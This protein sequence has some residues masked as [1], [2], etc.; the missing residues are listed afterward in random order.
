MGMVFGAML[1]SACQ[2]TSNSTNH[3]QTQL[4]K[5][6]KTQQAVAGSLMNVPP[7]LVSSDVGAHVTL[8]NAIKA[9]LRSSFSYHSQISYS[10]ELRERALL[11][12]TPKQLAESDNFETACEHTHDV[13]Y[14]TLAKQA[15]AD[16][17][18]ISSDRYI[19]QREK[20][21]TEF[22]ACKERMDNALDETGGELNVPE[23]YGS[24]TELDAK[25]ALLLKD[26]W[27]NGTAVQVTGN[28]QPLKGIVTALPTAQYK[29]R[30]ALI[31]ANQPIVMDLKAGKLYLWADNLALANATWLDKKLGLTWKHK[32]L[33]VNMNDGSLPE[34]FVK[35]LG[36]AYADSRIVGSVNEAKYLSQDN[37]VQLFEDADKSAQAVLKTANQVIVENHSGASSLAQFYQTMTQKYPILLERPVNPEEVVL[38]SKTVMQRA[39]ALIKKRLDKSTNKELASVSYYGLKNG[40]LVWHYHHSHL[41]T[42]KKTPEPIRVKVLTHFNDKLVT[43][44]DRLPIDHQM[45]HAGNQ[46]DFLKYS[47]D[48]MKE[49]KA[50]DDANVQLVARTLLAVLVGFD[51][52]SGIEI[53][54][55]DNESEETIKEA[56]TTDD[57]ADQD[58]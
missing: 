38:D 8:S 46:V 36:K 57:E 58:F 29:S 50:G 28:Y 9:T 33:M 52:Q 30:N 26:Y 42:D 54:S 5:E 10:N 12:A 1:L 23:N 16:G 41:A 19:N 51:A 56:I 3:W 37:F 31:M 7:T 53:E 45:P 22:L 6:L 18:D 20:L 55:S 49:L 15:I 17:V 48:L 13:G 14:V 11:F 43:T 27:F 32:W 44:F 24:H 34:G 21:K 2:T 35:E 40:K 25:K 4:K 39:F 47:N